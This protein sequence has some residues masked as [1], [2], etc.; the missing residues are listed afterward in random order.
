MPVSVT[1]LMISVRRKG[2]PFSRSNAPCPRFPSSRPARGGTI[3][4]ANRN[5]SS[6]TVDETEASRRNAGR[7]GIRSELQ[8]VQR[9]QH[10]AAAMRDAGK[11]R[12]ED[13]EID[14]HARQV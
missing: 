8:R 2:A 6:A 7:E 13:D 4:F 14:R 12:K 5:A 1:P 3:F 11:H 9:H 10:F